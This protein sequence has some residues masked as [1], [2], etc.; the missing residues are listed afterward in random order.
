MS[1]TVLT[2]FGGNAPFGDMQPR[3]TIVAALNMLSRFGV[4]VQ[5]LSPFYH[6]TCF[7]VGAGPDYVNA[8]A[9]LSVPDDMP[10]HRLLEILHQV[11]ADLGRLREKRWGARTI[12]IDLL[13]VDDVILP[14]V[15]SH[16]L[17]RN[18]PLAEQQQRAPDTLILPHPR[19]QDRA[20]VLVPLADV[21]P[22]WRHPV[23]G[24]TVAQMLAALPKQDRAEVRLFP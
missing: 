23:L 10:P 20:F 16:A 24:T 9:V 4:E 2:A 17:W 1:K 5:H 8:A 7:P 19:I 21:A 15:A 3:D 22:D 11:E 13:A 6:T 12:D 18:L 14:D